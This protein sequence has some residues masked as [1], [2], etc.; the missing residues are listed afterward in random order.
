MFG[1]FF[2]VLPEN[3]AIAELC[4]H[5]VR[6]LPSLDIDSTPDAFLRRPESAYKI[7]Q[8]ESAPQ[9]G[10]LSLELFVAFLDFLDIQ[11]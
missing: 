6:L 8:L 11:S 9:T 2:A 7:K 4:D 10:G 3:K 1:D 5:I